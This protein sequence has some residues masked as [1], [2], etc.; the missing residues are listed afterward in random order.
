MGKG[1]PGTS[2]IAPSDRDR[3]M[4][5]SEF[6][7]RCSHYGIR[8]FI[9][10]ADWYFTLGPNA[11]SRRSSGRAME[12]TPEQLARVLYHEQVVDGEPLK[13]PYASLADP[14]R[15]SFRY[16]EIGRQVNAARRWSPKPNVGAVRRRGPLRRD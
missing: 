7:E 10:G 15:L 2:R 13:V 11:T 12:V 4:T 6:L 1:L 14:S 5:E 16:T 8:C 9:A 3:A